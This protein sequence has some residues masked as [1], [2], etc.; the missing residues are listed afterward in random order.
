M[1]DHQTAKTS[2]EKSGR[3]FLQGALI[4]T[5]A[6]VVVKIIGSLNWIFLSWVL[7]GEGIGIYQ[8]AFPLYLLA[9]SISDAGI[10]VAVSILTAERAALQDYRGAQRVFRLSFLLLA[11]T[12]SSLDADT[13]RTRATRWAQQVEVLGYVV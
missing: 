9:L 3:R 13:L 12:G 11:V 1:S 6:G 4:L 8:I 5:V 2:T 10:P 7:G